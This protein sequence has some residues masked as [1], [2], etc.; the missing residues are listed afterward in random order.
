MLLR[1]I[2]KWKT[3]AERSLADRICF[4]RQIQMSL[5]SKYINQSHLIGGIA[6]PSYRVRLVWDFFQEC[7][8]KKR[9][10][11][12]HVLLTPHPISRSPP[13]FWKAFP[14]FTASFSHTT[15]MLKVFG[16][17]CRVFFYSLREKNYR[18]AR[19]QQ[20]QQHLPPF[21]KAYWTTAHVNQHC[22]PLS[23]PSS[24]TSDSNNSFS[25]H[26]EF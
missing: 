13:H 21:S 6:Q 2:S 18:I 22:L 3:K 24:T 23:S 20:E 25:W 10:L 16:L 9:T 12:L 11:L 19:Y 8:E 26:K 1:F 7:T 4:P 5:W 17:G 15:G 14:C